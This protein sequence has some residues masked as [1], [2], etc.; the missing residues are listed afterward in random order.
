M[1]SAYHA[2]LPCSA[3]SDSSPTL[4]R[5]CLSILVLEL[6]SVPLRHL[7]ALPVPIS[8]VI[9][10]VICDLLPASSLSQGNF[11]SQRLSLF[12]DLHQLASLP[13]EPA[14]FHSAHMSLR[15]PRLCV[16]DP[17]RQWLLCRVFGN[18]CAIISHAFMSR[19]TVAPI[20]PPLSV[21]CQPHL[22]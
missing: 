1:T 4:Q 16:S 18:G 13:S 19:Q 7:S 14:G 5:P 8:C 3:A 20:V 10:R 22:C 2:H 17:C 15:C 21:L 12:R 9:S 11:A 6:F